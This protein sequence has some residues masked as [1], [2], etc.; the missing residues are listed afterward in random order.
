M[1]NASKPRDGDGETPVDGWC[2]TRNA[3][4]GRG[5]GRARE[6]KRRACMEWNARVGADRRRRRCVRRRGYGKKRKKIPVVGSANAR[7]AWMDRVYTASRSSPF[8]TPLA[9]HSCRQCDAVASAT[10]PHS[11]RRRDVV[12]GVS[13]HRRRACGANEFF[14]SHERHHARRRSRTRASDR[15]RDVGVEDDDDGWA[16]GTERRREGLGRWFVYVGFVKMS[17]Y[18]NAVYGYT[19]FRY[20]LGNGGGALFSD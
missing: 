19:H 15:A 12:D 6:E 10:T 11:T 13:S 2:D 17:L 9:C 8:P 1:F 20:T 4:D 3:P 14:L 16:F 7:G 5:L 18:G